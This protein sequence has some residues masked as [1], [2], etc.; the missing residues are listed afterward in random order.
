MDLARLA[1]VLGLILGDDTLL[2]PGWPAARRG[3]TQ[4]E[5]ERGGEAR[6]AQL[7]Y[8]LG[9]DEAEIDEIVRYALV[10]LRVEI[11]DEFEKRELKITRHL[12]CHTPIQDT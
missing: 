11:G 1:A 3:V 10:V 7:L 8:L 5:G 12:K 2:H 6:R 9:W 4:K